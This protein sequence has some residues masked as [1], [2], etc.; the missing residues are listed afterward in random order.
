MLEVRESTLRGALSGTGNVASDGAL[1]EQCTVSNLSAFTLSGSRAIGCEILYSP[2]LGV[3]AT[4]GS[5]L[6]HCRIHHNGQG[7]VRCDGSEVRNCAIWANLS[8]V[9]AGGGVRVVNS[10][11]VRACT[12]VENEAGT[13]GGLYAEPGATIENTIVFFNTA[14]AQPN[15][16]GA[17]ADWS[18]SCASPLPPGAG[19]IDTNPLFAPASYRLTAGSL[20]RDAGILESWMTNAVDLD[21]HPRVI[22]VRPDLGAYEFVFSE[23]DFDGDGVSNAV[24]VS[25]LGSDPNRADTDDDGLSD[26]EEIIAGT[27]ATNA[28]SCFTLH[29]NDAA[30][31]GPSGT[32]LRWPS[33]EGRLYTVSKSTNLTDGFTLILATDL[34]ATPPL[35]TFTDTTAAAQSG[36]CYRISVR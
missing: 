20:C 9:E 31:P 13:A 34:P 32:V 16:S 17:G 10:G 35:N 1:F 6:S 26:G 14:P 18:H 3:E 11:S 22:N 12:V 8:P 27:S 28:T 33:A 19:N 5:L 36:G 4:G 15:W 7:G 30:T 24:E 2:G 23:T 25:Q 29:G 21:G